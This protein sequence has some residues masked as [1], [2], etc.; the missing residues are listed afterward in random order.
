MSP[1][2]NT[3]SVFIEIITI[4]TESTTNPNINSPYVTKTDFPTTIKYLIDD[5]KEYVKNITAANKDQDATVLEP[6]D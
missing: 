5:F 2:T 3:L 4:S 1:P 6:L